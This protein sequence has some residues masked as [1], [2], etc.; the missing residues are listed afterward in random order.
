[1]SHR[2]LRL[3]EIHGKG[4]GVVARHDLPP[5]A[6]LPYVGRTIDQAAF[7]ALCEQA[8][9]NRALNLTAYVIAEGRPGVYLNADPRLPER[10]HMWIA[11]RVNE[12]ARGATANTIIRRQLAPG[13]NGR[14]LCPVLITVRHVNAGE[15]LTVK[16]GRSSTRTYQAGRAPKKPAWL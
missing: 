1:M 7:D 10:T 11:G 3:V 13:D 8:K 16:Y 15:E 9:H 4:V 14:R 5:N 6:R 2:D 12:P